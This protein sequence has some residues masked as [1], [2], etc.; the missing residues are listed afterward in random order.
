MKILN[1]CKCRSL[2]TASCA[3]R[4]TRL[5]R[6]LAAVSC[7]AKHAG[8]SLHVFVPLC[9]SLIAA[10]PS[11]TSWC[12]RNPLSEAQLTF[13]SKSEWVLLTA[14]LLSNE[15]VAASQLAA[16]VL[17]FLMLSNCLYCPLH[18]ILLLCQDVQCSGSPTQT[19]NWID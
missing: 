19:V 2:S 3:G 12:E 10:L 15:Q 14:A 13:M 6:M 17:S 4:T 18:S 9:I 16:V 1:G 7:A 8:L 5:R 11:I